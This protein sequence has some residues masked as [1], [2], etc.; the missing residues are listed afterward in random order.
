MKV[1]CPTCH[2]ALS[3]PD[4]K[5]PPSGSISFKCPSCKGPI[6]VSRGAEAKG[7]DQTQDVVLPQKGEGVKGLPEMTGDLDSEID[8]LGEGKFKALVADTDNVA[9]IAP[10]LKKLQYQITLAK[11]QED[12]CKKLQF[13]TYDLIIIN[14]RFGGADPAKNAL[15]KMLEPIQMDRRR[16]ILIALVGKTFKTL[17]ESAAFTLSADMVF[18]E[19]DFSNF[20]L[21]LRKALNDAK[22]K[23]VVF[24]QMLKET[25]RGFEV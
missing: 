10:A 2:K 16:K 11:S 13:N 17:D 20:E 18:N 6:S 19:A 7:L 22:Y 3:V 21:L 9:K 1:T 24:R 4:E 5:I 23:Y 25:G 14:E 8:L 15:H 12:A